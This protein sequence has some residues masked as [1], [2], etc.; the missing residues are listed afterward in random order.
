MTN[1]EKF[2]ETFGFE[3]N[4][5]V[6]S[7][8][9]LPFS[10]CKSEGCV[11]ESSVDFYPDI[12]STTKGYFHDCKHCALRDWWNK[13]YNACFC[14][15]EEYENN[16]SVAEML[17]KKKM[18]LYEKIVEFLAEAEKQSGNYD[19]GG[20]ELIDWCRMMICRSERFRDKDQRN[21]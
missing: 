10:V 12:H 21:N 9:P 15:K 13:E 4:I 7:R 5:G 11:K 19:G 17:N 2:K 6:T 3:P 14:I 8:C 20:V 16:E 18:W 1:G